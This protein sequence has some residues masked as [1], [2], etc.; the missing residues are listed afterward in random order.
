MAPD[1]GVF[2]KTGGIWKIHDRRKVL[3]GSTYN[4]QFHVLCLCDVDLNIE[5]YDASW[6]TTIS[7]N[8]I[9]VFTT[10]EIW[11]WFLCIIFSHY[12]GNQYYT[13]M[14]CIQ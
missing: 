4:I 9:L 12:F 3:A 8:I 11:K 2:K 14:S 1:G 10:I 6:N 7:P 13:D 5:F